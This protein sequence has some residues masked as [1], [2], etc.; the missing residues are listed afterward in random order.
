MSEA[1]VMAM[2]VAGA[3]AAWVAGFGAGVTVAWIR[4]LGHVA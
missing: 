1:Q 4:K 3:V 2:V